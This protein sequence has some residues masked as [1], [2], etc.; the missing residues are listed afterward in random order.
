MRRL[1]TNPRYTFLGLR[2]AGIHTVIDVGANIGQFAKY[3]RSMLPEARVVCFEPL[4]APFQELSAWANKQKGRVSVHNVALGEKDGLVEMFQHSDF[5]PSSSLLHSTPV[6]HSYYPFTK[7]ETPVEV[8]L[9]SLDNVLDH[10]EITLEPGI[11]IKLDAQGYEDRVIRGARRTF[12]K[13]SACI[14]EIDFD[15]LYAGQCTF[16]EVWRL[17]DDLGYRYAGN[18]DQTYA[19]DGHVIFADALFIR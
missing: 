18:F 9:A 14:S 15:T 7:R 19:I 11:L 6:S 3:I 12:A 1:T 16:S 13:A 17:L 10:F 2:N 8:R 4:P 5:S